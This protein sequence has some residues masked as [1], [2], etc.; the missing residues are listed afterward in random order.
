MEKMVVLFHKKS[1]GMPIT[2]VTPSRTFYT[3]VMPPR[4]FYRTPPRKALPHVLSGRRYSSPSSPSGDPDSPWVSSL[5]SAGETPQLV[6]SF[7]G[8]IIHRKGRSLGHPERVG[9]PG[10]RRFWDMGLS[11]LQRGTPRPVRKCCV[12]IV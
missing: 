2:P 5:L 7:F 11:G 9:E 1:N 4:T 3:P 10:R 12:L 6:Q 8:F